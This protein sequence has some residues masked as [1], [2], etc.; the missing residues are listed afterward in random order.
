MR[1][2][3]ALVT[4]ALVLVPAAA[5]RADSVAFQGTA[6]AYAG[7]GGADQVVISRDGAALVFR[8]GPGQPLSAPGTCAR[9]SASEVSCPA[10]SVTAVTVDLLGGNDTLTATLPDTPATALT[11]H[12][13]AGNDV[14]DASGTSTGA[15]FGD[16]G[17]DRLLAGRTSFDVTGGAGAD[18]LGGGPAGSQTRFLTGAAADGPDQVLGGPGVDLAS[19]E[20]RTAPLR[21]TED[22]VADD[23]EAGE[24][25]NIAS[26]VEIVVGGA[27]ADTLAGGSGPNQLTA[28]AGDDTVMA[29]DAGVDQ[30]DCGAGND[31]AVLD[32]ADTTKD[33]EV[34]QR[35][36]L[37]VAVTGLQ[38]RYSW[39]GLRRGL[40]FGATPSAP[41]RWTFVLL[42]ARRGSRVLTRRT[43]PLA[44]GPR[45]VTLK[46]TSARLGARRQLS[47][48]VRITAI[49]A[50]GTKT[51]V[52]RRVRITP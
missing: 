20:S 45:T 31:A 7:D 22:G 41:A 4:V 39:T 42:G 21:L 10:G 35:P 49:A 23:G 6:L 14:L 43:L 15:L 27:G 16:D 36:E 52:I 30:V 33:C 48:R 12:G 28:G 3:L 8:A 46:P 1:T 47:L 17:D 18:E 34:E 38:S 51:L 44:V 2:S 37:T 19:Y 13:G 26:A 25:D 5:A 40:R 29:R 9:R 11:A 50:D 24:G 32:V